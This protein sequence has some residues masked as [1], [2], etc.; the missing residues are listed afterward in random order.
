MP[1]TDRPRRKSVFRETGLFDDYSPA[2]PPSPPPSR[3]RLKVRFRSSNDVFEH[4]STEEEWEDVAESDTEWN[5]KPST[6]LV[7]PPPITPTPKV[8][9]VH[10]LSLLAFVLAIAIPMTHYIPFGSSNRP[11]LGA[12]GV[13]VPETAEPIFED[14]LSRR[15]TDPTDYCKRWSQQSAIVNGT[16]YLYGGR[17]STS[18]SQTSNTWSKLHDAL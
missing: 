16:L 7:A 6:V 11:M 10:R 1:T 3:P 12:T 9:L 17:K 13:P 18:S 8:S 15:D 5:W 2:M 14:V 4:T